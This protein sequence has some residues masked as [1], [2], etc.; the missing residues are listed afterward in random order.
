MK[1]KQGNVLHIILVVLVLGAGITT[2]SFRVIKQNTPQQAVQ[3]P[4]EKSAVTTVRFADTFSTKDV[5]AS[6]TIIVMNADN[7]TTERKI[8]DFTNYAHHIGV[9]EALNTYC[10]ARTPG[11]KISVSSGVFNNATELYKEHEG[12]VSIAAGCNKDSYF[13][14]YLH[15]QND[16][17][18]QVDTR[19][20]EASGSCV[21]LDYK[22]Y[23]E[24]IMATCYEGTEY[25]AIKP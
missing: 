14:Y 13:R 6:D 10:A 25:R 5:V 18:W 8:V 3:T 7:T 1:H 4:P 12:H 21:D 23:S 17:S 24:I 9:L 15:K 19:T 20:Q 11:T 2:A 22:G 16:G